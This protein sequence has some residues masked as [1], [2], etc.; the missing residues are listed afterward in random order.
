MKLHY[1]QRRYLI[2]TYIEEHYRSHRYPPTPNEIA[3]VFGI[4]PSNAQYHIDRLVDEGRLQRTPHK[5]RSLRP[6]RKEAA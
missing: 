3:L 4:H 6:T 2:L 5:Q 1:N